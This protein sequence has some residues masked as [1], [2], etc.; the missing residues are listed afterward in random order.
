[1]TSLRG[2]V[3][4]RPSPSPDGSTSKRIRKCGPSGRPLTEPVERT[5]K[6]PA[7]LHVSSTA[8]DTDFI[9]RANDVYAEGAIHLVD[10]RPAAGALSGQFRKTGPDEEGRDLQMIVNVGWLSQVFAPGHRIRVTI[11]STMADHFEPNPNT[12]EPATIEPSKRMFVARNTIWHDANHASRII[13]HS[14]SG[15][16]KMELPLAWSAD[17]RSSNSEPSSGL[18][19]PC[20]RYYRVSA[21]C[22]RR[23]LRRAVPQLPRSRRDLPVSREPEHIPAPLHRIAGEAAQP[24]AEAP[25]IS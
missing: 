15:E 25:K 13:I 10:Q 2:D 5:G 18:T 17:A 9:V 23:H 21:L 3:R 1:M 14:A 16:F 24:Y 19:E 4:P 12:G 8:P 20:S 6:V 22:D 11:A 7:E